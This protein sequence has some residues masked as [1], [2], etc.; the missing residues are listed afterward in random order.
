MTE[1]LKKPL[2]SIVVIAVAAQWCISRRMVMCNNFLTFFAGIL[3]MCYVLFRPS[4][5][6]TS[7]INSTAQ[8]TE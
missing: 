1:N 7:F 3:F 6:K 5:S 4:L 2:K 8:R